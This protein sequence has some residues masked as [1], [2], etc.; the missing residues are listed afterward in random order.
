MIQPVL[1]ALVLVV[2]ATLGPYPAQHQGTGRE[3]TL[4]SA[5]FAGTKFVPHSALVDYEI[6]KS[7]CPDKQVGDVDLYVFERAGVTCAKLEAAR[8][9][10]F[11]S[12]SIE[13]DGKRLPVGHSPSSSFFQQAS[14]NI[15]GL[16]TGFQPGVSIVFT[17]IDTSRNG[18]W[19]GRIT[20]PPNTYAGKHY[21]Y[22]GTFNASWCGTKTS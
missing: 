9:A 15:I 13:T 22:N 16:T 17:R 21:A 12:Y 1:R 3:Q 7:C 5:V 18:H 4:G 6:G 19:H 2:V 20:V 11:F 10:R 8:S 14:F